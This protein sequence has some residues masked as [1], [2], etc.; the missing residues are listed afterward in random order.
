M[1]TDDLDEPGGTN[2]L[3]ELEEYIKKAA[4]A[5]GMEYELWCQDE[6]ISYLDRWEGNFRRIIQ[7]SLHK[8]AG[9]LFVFFIPTLE[10]YEAKKRYVQSLVPKQWTQTLHFSDLNEQR[11]M[12]M[13]KRVV[14]DS[15]Y[16]TPAMLNHEDK[17]VEEYG[18]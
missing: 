8:N 10:Q 18:N 14:H 15:Y 9:G 6:A 17:M 5:N 16:I 3:N 13:V 7:I 12:E 4:E 2:F 1:F 11:F